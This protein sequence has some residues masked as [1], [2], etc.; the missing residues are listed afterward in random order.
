[1]I[2]PP[3]TPKEAKNTIGD[4]EKMGLIKKDRQGFYKQVD[5]AISTGDEVRSLHVANYQRDMFD[6]GRRALDKIKGQERDLSGLVMT[7]SDEKFKL[8]KEEIQ[9]FRKRMLQIAV[10]DENPNRVIRCN[11]QIFPVTKKVKGDK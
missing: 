4:L 9:S 3:I 11:F 1:M 8:M 2:E 7:V 10:D 6:L 5:A